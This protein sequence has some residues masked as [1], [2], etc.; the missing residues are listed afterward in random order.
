M[1]NTYTWSMN[2]K[3]SVLDGRDREDIVDAENVT[4][5]GGVHLKIL[6]AFSE[7]T[8]DSVLRKL[9]PY[10]AESKLILSGLALNQNS[11]EETL[12]ALWEQV[13]DAA[14]GNLTSTAS[15]LIRNKN[16]SPKVLKEIWVNEATSDSNRWG[17]MNHPK[18]PFNL[19]VIG[20][21]NV[22][23]QNTY[24]V[25]VFKTL[26]GDWKEQLIKWVIPDEEEELNWE[27]TPNSW[28]E[29]LI[30]AEGI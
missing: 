10:V 27:Q 19:K 15:N 22:N 12:D 4:G 8:E 21:N 6:V 29:G 18:C 30:L 9:V 28:L 5:D 1:T 2:Q 14:D 3:T 13:V 7:D 26:Q 24:N 17:I 20:V 16:L 23:I 11:S 25:P